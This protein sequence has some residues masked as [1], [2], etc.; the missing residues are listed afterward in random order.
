MVCATS[1]ALHLE[2]FVV[3][4]SAVTINSP[5][6]ATS[7]SA[8]ETRDPVAHRIMTVLEACAATKQPLTVTQ[9][10]EATG[11]AKTTVHRMAWRLVEL[12]LLEHTDDGFSIGT[13]MLTLAYSNP[14]VNEI[15]AAAIPHLL[16]IQRMTGTANLAILTCGKALVIDGLFTQGLGRPPLIGVGL[17]LHCTSIGK[18]ILARMDREQQDQLL[19]TGALPAATPRSLV[20]P[21]LIRRHLDRVAETGVAFSNEEFQQGMIGIASGFKARDGSIAAIGCVGI[22]TNRTVARSAGLVARAAAQ[23]ERTFDRQSALGP[24]GLI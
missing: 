2:L 6:V 9:L 4:E 14:V 21:A 16:E 13:K 15:R 5:L 23:L 1:A 7:S 11:L 19:G 24:L 17:P 12:G 22:T 10:V 20:H 3:L 8:I 18:A